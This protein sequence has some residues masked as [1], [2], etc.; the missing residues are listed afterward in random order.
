MSDS[1]ALHPAG[2]VTEYVDTYG[3][4]C[5]CLVMPQGVMNIE[6]EVAMQVEDQIAVVSD[7]PATPVAQLPDNVPLYLLQSRY[8]PSDKMAERVRCA[9]KSCK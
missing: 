8:C 7:A 5:Q 3:N 1:Y 6:V 4:L 2:P 9:L